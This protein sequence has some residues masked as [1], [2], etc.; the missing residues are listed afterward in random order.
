MLRRIICNIPTP[1]LNKTFAK[2]YNELD[3]EN[4]SESYQARLVLKEN[5]QRMPKIENSEET[6]EKEISIT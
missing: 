1:S 2:M 3:T 6:S 5:Y 4:Y